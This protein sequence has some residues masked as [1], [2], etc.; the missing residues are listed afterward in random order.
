[1]KPCLLFVSLVALNLMLGGCTHSTSTAAGPCAVPV[2]VISSGPVIQGTDRQP[3][4]V[5]ITDQEQLD[6]LTRHMTMGNRIPDPLAALPTIDFTE[7]G[8]LVIW[9]SQHPTGGYALELAAQQAEIK[10]ATILVPVRRITPRQGAAVVQMI[11]QPYL[12]LRI[13]KGNYNTI[14]IID[15]DDPARMVVPT[16]AQGHLPVDHP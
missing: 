4:G 7:E 1:M 13:G 5:W 2:A 16:Q 15:P 12:M 10:D 8:V 11:T 6:T 3:G 14:T 9:M